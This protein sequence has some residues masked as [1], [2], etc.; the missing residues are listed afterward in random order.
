[1]ADIGGAGVAG[2]D[3]QAE[4]AWDEG[5]I[6]PPSKLYARGELQAEFLDLILKQLKL[7]DIVRGDIMCEVGGVNIGERGLQ[8]AHRALWAGDGRAAYRGLSRRLGTCICARRIEA[9]PD[10]VYRGEKAIDDDVASDKPLTIRVDLTVKGSEAAFDF[11]RSDPQSPRY[12]NSTDAFTRSMATL[13]LFATLEHEESNH[14]SV[15]PLSFV[16]PAGLCT[17]AA[18]PASTVLTT[19]S[20]AE[21]VQEAVQLALAQAVPEKVAAPST[22]LIF[23]LIAY[24]HPEKKRLDVNVDF[25]FRCNRFRRNAGLRRLGARRPCAGNGDGALPRSGDPRNDASGAHRALRAG[26]RQRRSG[27]ISRRQRPCLPGAASGGERAGDGIRL[28]QQTACGAERPVRRPR[29]PEPSR[30]DDRAG[31][32]R[33]RHHPRSTVSSRS[34]RAM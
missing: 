18:F 28:G 6:I 15:R 22:K 32:G 3:P 2:Y 27:R 23:P 9:I 10:G 14:G 8:C 5:V 17:N 12:M 20:M 16:N 11:S 31:G 30:F 34:T 33:A 7:P 29:S 19:C 24:M 25:F 13:T 21:C 26:D 1:M 4:T